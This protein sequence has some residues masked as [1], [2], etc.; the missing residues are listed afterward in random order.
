MQKISN[1]QIRKSGIWAF[2]NRGGLEV[3]GFF[4][5]II[6]ARLIA[7]AEFGLLAMIQ[8]FVGLARF[9]QNFGFAEALIQSKRVNDRDFSTVFYFNLLTGIILGCTPNMG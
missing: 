8:V 5:G 1:T 6:L 9:I 2:I 3:S 4:F 7:P